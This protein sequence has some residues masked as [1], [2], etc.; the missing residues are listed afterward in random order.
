MML[1]FKREKILP[2]FLARQMTLRKLATVAGLSHKATERAVNGLTVT[3]PVVDK[4]ARALNFDALTFL[5]KP[6]QMK[7]AT[8]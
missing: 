8:S 4:I 3:A 1:R 2:L 6:A 7:E 5:D